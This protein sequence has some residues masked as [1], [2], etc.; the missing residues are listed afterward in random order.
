MVDVLKAK[1]RIKRFIKTGKPVARVRKI[2]ENTFEYKVKHHV[3]S[4][5]FKTDKLGR[6]RQINK[7]Q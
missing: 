5:I 1:R 3:Q 7:T 4:L 2:D 6:L